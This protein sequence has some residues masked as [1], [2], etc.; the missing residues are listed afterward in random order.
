M[1]R[2]SIGADAHFGL[3]DFSVARMDL[4][5][6]YFNPSRFMFLMKEIPSTGAFLRSSLHLA[7]K[8]IGIFTGTGN[9]FAITP[10]KIS[11]DPSPEP[12]GA[13]CR[14]DLCHNP[15]AEG[16]AA[17]P[18]SMLKSN[19]DARQQWKRQPNSGFRSP[20]RHHLNRSLQQ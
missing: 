20:H 2:L 7:Q 8:I 9:V 15:A 19:C 4:L 12:S 3:I 17:C 16:S 10:S 18:E 6:S 5:S 11:R 13:A 14:S 1:Q